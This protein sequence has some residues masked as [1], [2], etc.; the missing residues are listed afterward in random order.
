MH[1][2]GVSCCAIIF[3]LHSASLGLVL[4]EGLCFYHRRARRKH[5]GFVVGVSLG[6]VD[7]SDS[8]LSPCSFENAVERPVFN[9]L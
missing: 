1:I 2:C 3:L 9:G 5:K 8:P 4:Q 6:G 7:S